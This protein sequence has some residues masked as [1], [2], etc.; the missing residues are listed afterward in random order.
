MGGKVGGNDKGTVHGQ[1]SNIFRILV[2]IVLCCD[3]I[4][5]FQDLLALSLLGLYLTT[6]LSLS[7]SFLHLLWLQQYQP[8]S[9]LICHGSH[10]HGPLVCVIVDRLQA[11]PGNCFGLPPSAGYLLSLSVWL[12]ACLFPCSPLLPYYNIFL[13]SSCGADARPR[14][15]TSSIVLMPLSLPWNGPTSLVEYSFTL[16]TVC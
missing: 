16:A 2:L 3:G 11:R 15:F 6:L 5:C 10:I 8:H 13:F 7:F 1:S 12:P 9:S 14:S 4:C